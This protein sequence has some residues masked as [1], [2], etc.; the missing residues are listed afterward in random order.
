MKR[1][2]RGLKKKVENPSNVTPYR[3]KKYTIETAITEDP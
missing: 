3:N 1:I 2:F